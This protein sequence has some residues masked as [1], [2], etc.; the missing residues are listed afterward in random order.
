MGVIFITVLDVVVQCMGFRW[1]EQYSM[2]GLRHLIMAGAL[3][4]IIEVPVGWKG[5]TTLLKIYR[6]KSDKYNPEHFTEN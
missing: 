1:C 4:L 6:R 3:E 2:I 5:F